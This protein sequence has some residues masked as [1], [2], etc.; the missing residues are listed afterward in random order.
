MSEPVEVNAATSLESQADFSV[1]EAIAPRVQAALVK[2]ARAVV[3]EVKP[4]QQEPLIRW[5]ARRAFAYKVIADP[6]TFTASAQWLIAAA[7]PGLLTTY[8][9]PEAGPGALADADIEATVTAEWDTLT[10]V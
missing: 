10:G 6:K 5:R 8:H 3:A 2:V 1:N 9:D 7:S 4:T